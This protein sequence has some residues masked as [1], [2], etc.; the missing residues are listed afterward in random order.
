MEC[1]WLS[2]HILQTVRIMAQTVRIMAQTKISEM[3]YAVETDDKFGCRRSGLHR[4]GMPGIPPETELAYS[5]K[6]D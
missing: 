6:L 5:T 4:I 3:C 1:F 2:G